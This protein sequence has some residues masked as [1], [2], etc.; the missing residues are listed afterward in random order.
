MCR[1]GLNNA[2]SLLNERENNLIE[3]QDALNQERILNKNLTDKYDNLLTQYD[4]EKVTY[5][6]QHS[7]LNEKVK[8]VIILVILI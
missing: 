3:S 8:F 7:Q 5:Q 4:T 2:E 1:T 6:L